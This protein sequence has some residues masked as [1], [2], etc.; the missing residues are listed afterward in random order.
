MGG[1]KNSSDQ[2]RFGTV[3]DCYSPHPL[4]ISPIDFIQS[5]NLKETGI[6]EKH[7]VRRLSHHALKELFRHS[8]ASQINL[9]CFRRRCVFLFRLIA[10]LA[11]ALRGAKPRCRSAGR[12]LNLPGSLPA[13]C[14]YNATMLAAFFLAHK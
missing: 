14:T 9:D 8:D 11:R 7:F 13:A 1:P 10:G 3:A 6:E 4:F 5:Q 2:T 12:A